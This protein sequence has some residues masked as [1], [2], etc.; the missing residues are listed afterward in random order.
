MEMEVLKL[1][2]IIDLCRVG[3]NFKAF[4]YLTASAS[5]VNKTSKVK[6]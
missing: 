6:N 1:S 3:M 4:K 2:G 5:H